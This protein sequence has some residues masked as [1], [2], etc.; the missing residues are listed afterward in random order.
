MILTQSSSPGLTTCSG[1]STWCAAISEMCTRPS[2]P[3]PDLH[4]GAERHQLGDAAVHELAH[5]VTVGEL[6]PRVL[7][8]G[9]ERQADPLLVEVD[10]ENLHVDLVADL[11]DRGGVVDV[12]PAELGHVHEPVHPAEVD[13]GTEVHD[14]GDH[15]VRCAR[16]GCRLARK[17]LRCSF[18]VSSSQ[19]RRDR[20]TLLRL[21]SSSMIL[22]S[23]IRPT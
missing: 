20:T 8:G 12:L 14:R 3:S 21:R 7:L 4:E 15:A 2:M 18:C 19:A 23:M 1:R 6:L 10:V 17:S 5:L 22:A 13:E 11:H 16:P 9:L